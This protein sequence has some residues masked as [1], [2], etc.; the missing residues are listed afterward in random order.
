MLFER[1]TERA[2]QVVVLA[3]DEARILK[4]GYIGTEHILLGL[5]REN[6]GVAARILLDFDADQE[7]IRD[8]ILRALNGQGATTVVAKM[9][10]LG[11][12]KVGNALS[13]LE[14]NKEVNPSDLR[15]MRDHLERLRRRAERSPGLRQ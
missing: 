3:Q 14:D 8:S 9:L 12:D 2:R 4:H 5:V 7:R 1:Y 11:I 13:K 10:W 15:V 6:E